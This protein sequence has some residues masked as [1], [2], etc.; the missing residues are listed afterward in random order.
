[1]KKSFRTIY[2]LTGAV[3][4]WT[5]L[6]LQLCLVIAHRKFPLFETVVHFF[7]YFTILTN[8]L[9]AGCFTILAL[10]ESFRLRKRLSDAG[11]M[12]AVT[13]YILVVGLIYQIA[14]RQIWNPGGT[15]KIANE[16]LHSVA[17]LLFFLYWLVFVRK[18]TL[19]WRNIFTWLLYPLLYM[20]Y[21]M[22][23]GA[24]SGWYPYFF[25]NV[26]R[27]GYARVLL[28]SGIVCLVFITVFS[29]LIFIGR[30]AGIK[31]NT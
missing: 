5:A 22:T 6:T 7:S 17:P 24:I 29:L 13:A 28:N 2:A 23:H 19:S 12:T 25:I 30:K 10:P 4:G 14:L 11:T 21:I 31:K 9:A 8:I 20:A 16:L 27:L 3:T 1:M 26:S 15:Q 18:S